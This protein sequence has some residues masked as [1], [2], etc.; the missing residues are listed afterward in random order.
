MFLFYGLEE[1]FEIALSK[2][3]AASSLY[4]FEEESGS[5]LKRFGEDLK[6]VPL[7]ILVNEDTELL[8]I[9]DAL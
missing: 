3:L 1:C 9:I 8:E 2:G 5:I 4:Q 6:H 7:L